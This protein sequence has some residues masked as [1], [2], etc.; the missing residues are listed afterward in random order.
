MIATS[1]L[2]AADGFTRWHPSVLVALGY[3]LTFYFLALIHI[4][5]T[6]S[7]KRR[8]AFR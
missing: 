6:S 7:G 3:C 2:K 5:E 1:A 8:E 4:F